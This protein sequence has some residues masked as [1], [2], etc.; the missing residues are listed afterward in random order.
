MDRVEASRQR[1]LKWNE[2]V[3]TMHNARR[4]CPVHS[5]SR[6][7]HLRRAR[8]GWRST[9]PL[10]ASQTQDARL[11]QGSR[12]QRRVEEV[13]RVLVDHDFPIR[14]ERR[15]G[16][17]VAGSHVLEV[18]RPRRG[19]LV[20]GGGRNVSMVS[21]SAAWNALSSPAEWTRGWLPRTRPGPWCHRASRPR[22]RS[23][24]DRPT[25]PMPP[26]RPRTP[27]RRAQRRTA[28]GARPSSALR[29]AARPRQRRCRRPV[30]FHGKGRTR[31][32]PRQANPQ[33]P[34]LSRREAA[35][36]EAGQ[37]PVVGQ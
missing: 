33:A 30:R 25:P 27:P 21:H 22:T 36:G 16:V 20:D 26:I 28:R 18:R 35:R 32:P 34:S 15:D 7:R 23:G 11:G 3:Q 31:G 10:A 14:G 2:S 6:R 1:R 9:R 29:V 4:V 8:A 13:R 17:A 12:D 24:P 5:C 19:A 37:R